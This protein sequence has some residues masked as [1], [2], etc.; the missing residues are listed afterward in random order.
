VSRGRRVALKLAW[1]AFL[2]ASIVML[3]QVRHDFV[4]RAF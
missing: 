4:Y 3:G 1:M 2:I